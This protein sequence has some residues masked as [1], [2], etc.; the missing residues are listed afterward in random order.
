MKTEIKIEIAGVGIIF[1]SP[2]A[3]RHI[4][5]GEDYLESNFMKPSDV[6][7]HVNDC[8]ISGFGTGSPGKFIIRLFEN[9]YPNEE[10][11]NAMV[12]IRLGIEIRDNLLIFRDLYELME[13]DSNFPDEHSI[14]IENGFY[15]ITAYTD[16]PPSGIL[17]DNQTINLHFEKVPEKPK[18]NWLGVPD[19]SQKWG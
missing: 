4:K 12:A 14:A 11:N 9:E 16:I 18:L 5:D 17:G 2:F 13:W 10:I 19:M 3:V 6:A 1:Y 8:L 15:K 7:K